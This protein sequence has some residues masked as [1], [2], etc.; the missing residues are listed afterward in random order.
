MIAGHGKAQREQAPAL[1]KMPASAKLF[2]ECGG[3]PPLCY[4]ERQFSVASKCKER[5]VNVAQ[6][7]RPEALL[8]SYPAKASPLK[9]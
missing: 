7:F 5:R 3:L 8:D 2:A 1:H 4:A 6:V 9:R